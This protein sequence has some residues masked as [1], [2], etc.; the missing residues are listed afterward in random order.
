MAWTRRA[1]RVAGRRLLVLAAALPLLAAPPLFERAAA[2]ADTTPQD[3]PDVSVTLVLRAPDATA[4]HALAGETQGLAPEVRRDRARRLEP[5]AQALGR[6]VDTLR[7]AGLRVLDTTPWTVRA[8]GPASVVTRLFG[9]ARA[10]DAAAPTARALPRLPAGL[11]DVLVAVGG[12]DDRPALRPVAIPLGVQPAPLR[13]AYEGGDGAAPPGS[14][15]TDMSVATLQFSG[16]DARA[17]SVYATAAGI[18]APSYTPIS[19]NG[20]DPS[21]VA[22]NGDLEVALDQETI[23]SQAPYARQR[24][25]FAPNSLQGEIAALVRVQQ[26][27]D[28]GIRIP[29]LSTSWGICEDLVQG[30]VRTA[31]ETAFAGL[32]AR[33]VVVV[34]ASGDSGSRDCSVSGT[35]TLGV[36]YPASSPSVVGVG[37]TS[38][39]GPR[40]TAWTGSG[41]GQSS[42]FARPS[43]QPSSSVVAG[44]GRLVPD[45][46][47]DAATPVGVYRQGRGWTTA[48]GTSLS[49]PLV[50]SALHNML[51]AA[52]ATQV[53]AALPGALYAAEQAAPGTFRDILTGSNGDY[54]AGVGYDMVTGLGTP[55][56]GALG[57]RLLP[58]GT[59]PCLTAPA[60]PRQPVPVTLTAETATGPWWSGTGAPSCA[61]VSAPTVPNAVATDGGPADI[62][63]AR[64]SGGVC[65]AAVTAVATDADWP[66]PALRRPVPR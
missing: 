55:R 51:R 59:V 37:G 14:G 4:L 34:A 66:R 17:L 16:W 27:V 18:P 35:A 56:W 33:G 7:G 58:A 44:T 40:E 63:V 48:I 38:D 52:G 62:W 30:S 41:G 42:A 53:S 60:V 26:D 49:A 13:R 6:T 11:P 43:W 50:A 19:V 45:I 21:A 32:T 5:S 61:G 28:A 64:V 54:G 31:L 46:A 12:D 24:A 3:G 36:D 57:C 65:R 2:A 25:Y 39:P 1:R 8:E 10:V 20:A 15:A 47:V 9:S 23:A 29:V 22:G